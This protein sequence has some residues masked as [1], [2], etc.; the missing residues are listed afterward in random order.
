MAGGVDLVVVLLAS[1]DRKWWFVYAL[2]AIAG[3]VAGGYVTYLIAEK[4]GEK[5]LEQRFG[6]TRAGHVYNWF[7]SRRTRQ[8]R[9]VQLRSWT[10]S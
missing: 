8:A 3:E 1:H 5:T 2:M 6:K 10:I 9:R 7:G 4:G